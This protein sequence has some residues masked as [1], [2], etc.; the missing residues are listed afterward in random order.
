MSLSSEVLILSNIS[1]MV[2][3]EVLSSSVSKAQI[4]DAIEMIGQDKIAGIVF[5]QQ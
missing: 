2:I 3:F 5:Q 1:D 4:T